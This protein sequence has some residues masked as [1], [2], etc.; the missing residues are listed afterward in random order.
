MQQLPATA[1]KYLSRLVNYKIPNYRT[2]LFL[3][4]NLLS[5][6]VYYILKYKPNILN[7]HVYC[8]FLIIYL[9]TAMHLYK[10]QNLSPF[11]DGYR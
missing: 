1:K 5:Y 4:V 2:K 9:T 7:E 6:I 8:F 10:G 11:V 3:I